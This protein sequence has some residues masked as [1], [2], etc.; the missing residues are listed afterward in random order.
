MGF[1]IS[2]GALVPGF[3]G[4]RISDRLAKGIGIAIFAILLAV[5]LAVGKCSYDASVIETHEAAQKAKDAEAIT[6]AD[7]DADNAVAPQEEA[8]QNEQQEIGAA[9]TEAKRADPK[10]AASTVGPVT[11]SYYDTLPDKEKR[12]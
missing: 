4:K 11:R 12:R 8:F 9:M 2:L 6:G 5:V 10:G 3:F 7:R 1:L